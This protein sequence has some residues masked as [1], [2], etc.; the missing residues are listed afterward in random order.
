MRGEGLGMG[1]ANAAA[2]EGLRGRQMKEG[3]EYHTTSDTSDTTELTS[4]TELETLYPS[5][6]LQ[7]ANCV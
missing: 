5:H 4:D 6:W 7:A 3:R 2:V 1:S